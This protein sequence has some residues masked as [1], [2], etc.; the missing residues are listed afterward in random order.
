MIVIKGIP[1]VS[2]NEYNHWHWTKKK[3]FKDNLRLLAMAATR[4]R[5]KGGYDIIFRFYFTGRRLD[6]INVVH[7]CKIWEDYL[8]QQDK[9]NR[10]ICISVMKG[11]EN[12]CLIELIKIEE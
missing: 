10:D 6:T 4:Q 5:F 2:F 3:K 9:D 7:F 1:K 12:K 8:F 11:K